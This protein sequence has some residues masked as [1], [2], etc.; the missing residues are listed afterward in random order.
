MEYHHAGSCMM[1]ADS[2][3]YCLTANCE[4]VVSVVEEERGPYRVIVDVEKC[5]HC[6]GGKSW[7]VEGPD[8]ACIGV[9]YGEPEGE[10]K[11]EEMAGML[12]A[13]FRL[14]AESVRKEGSP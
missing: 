14:G 5:P 9:S 12:N 10:T 1:Q 6:G 8:G 11:A 3:W 2:H 7:T 13:A 4:M